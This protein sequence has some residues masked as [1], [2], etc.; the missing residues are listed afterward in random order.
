MICDKSEWFND[1]WAKIHRIKVAIY[2]N[3]VQI[4]DSYDMCPFVHL[5][6]E[7]AIRLAKY[8]LSN[9]HAEGEEE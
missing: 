6:T 8:I 1:D 4:I 5:S 9:V 3:R 7:E 2:K